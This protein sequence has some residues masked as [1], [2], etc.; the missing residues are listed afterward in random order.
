MG[1]KQKKY[2]FIYKTTNLLSGRY[3]IGMHSTDNL[4]DGY[5]GSGNRIK[6]SIRKYGKENFSREI[7][8]FCETRVELKKREEEVVTLDEISKEECIN[9]RVGGYGGFSSEE[10]MIKCSEAGVKA[11]LK[12]LNEDSKF[13]YLMVEQGCTALKQARKDGKGILKGDKNQYQNWTGKKHTEETKVKMSESSKGNGIGE[14]NSQYG[15]CWITKDSINK[16][17][18]RDDLL[19]YENEGWVSGRKYD[20]DTLSNIRISKILYRKVE[21]PSYEQLID[22][23]NEIGYKGC[24]VKYGVYSSTI[25]KWKIIYERYLVK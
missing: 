2:H 5:L 24:G 1:R 25:R 20:S 4:E 3:Y 7:L 8:E 15:T 11:K 13:K 17:I 23:I 16:K 9:L 18:K 19:N 21:R 6:L 10:H 14:N 22:E 12:R